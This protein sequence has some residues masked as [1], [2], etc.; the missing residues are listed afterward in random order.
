LSYA[1]AAGAPAG[2]SI[3]ALSGVFTWVPDPYS[4]SGTYPVTI[5]VTDNGAI[6]KSDSTT[7]TINVLAVNH[8]PVFAPIPALTA[9]PKQ[10]LQLGVARF[11]SDPDRPAQTFNYALAAG[12]PFGASID[13]NSGLFTWRLPSSEHIGS[14]QIG[15]MVTDSGSPQLS[16]AT[17]LT[18]NVFDL[19]PPATIT[20]A[21]VVT[22]H[23]YA[24]TLKFSQPLDAL[25][26]ENPNNYI[27]IPVKRKNAKNAPVLTPIPLSVSYNP[28]TN[29]VTLMALANVK[30][31][32]TLQLTVI[33]TAPNG[34]AKISGV[35]LAGVRKRTGTNYVA[36]VT[37]KTIT[38]K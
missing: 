6:P 23:G 21:S 14:Y 37:G 28:K 34:V 33:G 5:I 17:S 27:L 1:L 22:K 24:I 25:T 35:L 31:K 12:A 16:T 10:T 8:P 2:A 20:R 36:F 26:A 38:H 9:Q 29:V 11:V 13:P 32:Q 18:V 19:G 30:K 7:F 15:V 3:G 4:S